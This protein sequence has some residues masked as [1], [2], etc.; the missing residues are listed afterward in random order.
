MIF[1]LLKRSEHFSK[2]P[3]LSPTLMMSVRLP[4]AFLNKGSSTE[5]EVDSRVSPSQ[6]GNIGDSIVIIQHPKIVSFKN[7]EKLTFFTDARLPLF[8]VVSKV[9][10][11]LGG[12]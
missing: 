10:Q 8:I 7:V 5:S 12:L 9:T 11:V 3:D 4:E 2:V 6:V 1:A